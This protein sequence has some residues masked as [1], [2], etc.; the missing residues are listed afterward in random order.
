MLTILLPAL[1]MYQFTLW[2]YRSSMSFT[3]YMPLPL[4]IHFLQGL[5]YPPDLLLRNNL[6]ILGLLSQLEG[7]MILY[8][9]LLKS[10]SY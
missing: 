8:S 4:G 10:I 5:V 6:N 3:R 1:T 7:M 9:C 2:R